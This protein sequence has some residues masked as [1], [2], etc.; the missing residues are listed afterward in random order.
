MGCVDF[1]S[2]KA[3]LLRPSRSIAKSAYDTVNIFSAHLP[4]NS[5]A[6]HM[7]RRRSHGIQ[8]GKA[9]GGLRPGVSKLDTNP[10]AGPMDGVGHLGQAR[11][12]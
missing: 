12:G 4:A 8:A 1:D 6:I 2:V 7:K 11:E 5:R 10:T 3:N 9:G